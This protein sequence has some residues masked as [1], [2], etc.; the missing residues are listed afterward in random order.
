MGFGLF[1]LVFVP[2]A[3]CPDRPAVECYFPKQVVPYNDAFDGSRRDWYATH[4]SAMEEPSLLAQGREERALRFLWLRSFHRPVAVRVSDS[5]GA[6]RLTA[7]ELDGFGGGR[8]GKAARRIDR[9]LS[10]EEVQEF[11]QL[12]SAASVWSAPVKQETQGRDGAQWV[13]EVVNGDRY[14]L[15]ERW[16]PENDPMRDLGIGLLELT[17]WEFRQDDLY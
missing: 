9:A 1:Y 4:L 15:V 11:H 6:M 17:E 5:S 14:R 16:S 13:F 12:V 8:P 2:A 7:V 3:A 10:D